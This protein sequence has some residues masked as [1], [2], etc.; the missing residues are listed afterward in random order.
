MKNNIVK[1]CN[2]KNNEVFLDGKSIFH[3]EE[4]LDFNEFIK[5]V[6]KN[7]EMEY[8][9]FYKMDPL[10]KLAVAGSSI[11]L[12]QF[13]EVDSEMAVIL[14]NKSSCIDID[15]VHQASISE[16]NEGYASPANFVYTLPN[17]ALGEISIKYKLRSENSF[18]IFEDFNPDFL[19]DYT[20]SLIG[21]KKTNQ[22]MCGWVEIF[23]NEYNA[24]LFIVK[25]EKGITF[26]KENLLKLI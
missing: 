18:F 16:E 6:Y 21:L 14:S 8:P 9:K 23:K 11:L 12:D 26:N 22:V 19:I 7:F 5:K 20:T 24:F 3:D 10:C 15:I 17:I 13:E 2:I 25:A 1:Y 4:K